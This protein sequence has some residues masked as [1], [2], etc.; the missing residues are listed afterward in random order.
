MVDRVA[1]PGRGVP[2]AEHGEALELA[3]LLA[4]ADARW[5]DAASA[6]RALDAAEALEGVLPPEW[7]H[8]RAAW[9]KASG[10]IA[11]RIA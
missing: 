6:L 5:G 1:V 9:R 10:E 8:R 4:E 11:E 2:E 7:E 3:L